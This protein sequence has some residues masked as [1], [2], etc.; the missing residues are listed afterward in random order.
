MT[1]SLTTQTQYTQ[2]TTKTTSKQATSVWSGY[3]IW[4]KQ[5]TISPS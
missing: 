3:N 2:A 1:V 4:Y 5:P